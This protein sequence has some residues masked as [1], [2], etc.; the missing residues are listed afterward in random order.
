MW[1]K[2]R[3]LPSMAP[4]PHPRL[5]PLLLNWE[6]ILQGQPE[7]WSGTQEVPITPQLGLGHPSF[8]EVVGHTKCF[9]QWM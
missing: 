8:S 2:S 6:M 4:G 1:S 5:A 9:Y 7:I 3:S